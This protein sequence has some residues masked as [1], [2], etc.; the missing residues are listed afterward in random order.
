M[1]R[2]KKKSSTE[3][4]THTRFELHL[5]EPDQL[6]ATIIGRTNTEYATKEPKYGRNKNRNKCPHSQ[7]DSEFEVYDSAFL[8]RHGSGPQEFT[9]YVKR[10]VSSLVSAR[11]LLIA[12]FG[13]ADP[14]RGHLLKFDAGTRSEP[15]ACVSPCSRTCTRS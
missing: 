3:E 14:N 8:L 4:S 10:F 9:F 15:R 6:F 12:W 11:L 1:P 2:Y 7:P 13:I 5:E